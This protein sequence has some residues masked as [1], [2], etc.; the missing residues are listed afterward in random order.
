MVAWTGDLEIEYKNRKGLRRHGA[1]ERL[2]ID[3]ELEVRGN[4]L[5]DYPKHRSMYQK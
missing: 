1:I 4:S 3:M 2:H 5:A